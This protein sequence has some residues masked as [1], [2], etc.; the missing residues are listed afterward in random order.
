MKTKKSLLLLLIV[1]SVHQIM[2][3]APPGD[4]GKTIFTA[5][6]AACHNV[7]KQV[8]GPALAGVSERRSIDW[9]IN[10]VHS[11][12][13]MVGKGDATAL[14]VYTKFNKIPMP[15]H[16]DLSEA[17]IKNI[18]QYIKA[19]TKTGTEKAVVVKSGKQH[20]AYLPTTIKGDY[21]FLVSY[22]AAVMFLVG[23]LYFSVSVGTYKQKVNEN[24][25]IQ[26]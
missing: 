1:F 25:N 26:F 14:E 24:I 22:L 19:E 21:Y 18:V 11:S 5:R 23:V 13:T 16:K 9:I 2:I 6:C 17:D 8:T 3:A 7:N 12:Q 4:E 10:F 20:P 15:D